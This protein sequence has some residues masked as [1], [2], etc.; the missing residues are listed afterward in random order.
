VVSPANNAAGAPQVWSFQLFAA[1]GGTEFPDIVIRL[2]NIEL[3]DGTKLSGHR[4]ITVSSAKFAAADTDDGKMHPGRVYRIPAGIVAF[5]EK[6]FESVEINGVR[7]ATRNVAEPHTFADNPWDP[8]R[9]YQWGMRDG[10]H[11]HW[12]AT[13]PGEPTG[14]PG[15]GSPDGWNTIMNAEWTAVND[16]CPIGWRLPTGNE[17]FLLAGAGHTPESNWNNTGV[18]GILFG[19]EPNQIFLPAVGFRNGAPG[20]NGDLTHPNRPYYWSST[21]LIGEQARYLDL[22]GTGE[23]S[24]LATFRRDALAIRCVAI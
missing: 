5:D 2:N 7:W 14:L 10:E 13:I 12:H 8:G 4:L 19:T 15:S 18:N 11:R 1:S 6:D 20:P 22:S 16:P 3:K 24:I 17:L 9:L 23:I 21:L